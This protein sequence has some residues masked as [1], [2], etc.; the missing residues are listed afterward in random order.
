M[1]E[2]RRG[3]EKEGRRGEE[4]RRTGERRIGGDE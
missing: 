1:E 2:K 3:G 4:V